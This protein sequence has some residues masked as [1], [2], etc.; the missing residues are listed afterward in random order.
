MDFSEKVGQERILS[1]GEVFSEMRG[2][3]EC[4][5]KSGEDDTRKK[6]RGTTGILLLTTQTPVSGSTRS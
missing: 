6:T 5:S 3:G 4:K 1:K 2:Y